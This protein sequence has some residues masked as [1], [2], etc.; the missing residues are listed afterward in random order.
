MVAA[1][2]EDAAFGIALQQPAH[3]DVQG[4]PAHVL[5]YSY[6]LVFRN[7]FLYLFHFSLQ[8][9]FFNCS[10]SDSAWQH[11]EVEI[12]DVS[13]VPLEVRIVSEVLVELVSS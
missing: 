7:L 4:L 2:G 5:A 8:L 10:R 11:L 13:L 1:R 6:Q 9:A 3:G 12:R